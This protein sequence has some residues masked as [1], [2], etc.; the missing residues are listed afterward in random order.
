M[1]CNVHPFQDHIDGLEY[2]I[3]KIEDLPIDR[4]IS[5][6]YDLYELYFENRSDKTFSL[7]GYS[8]DLGVNYTTLQEINSMFKDK[9]SKKLTVLSLAASTASIALGGIAKSAATTA[10][11]SVGS[12]RNRN[13]KIED[14]ANFLST[15]KTYVL[16]PGLTLSLLL[17]V[18]KYS[19]K[20]PYTIKFICRDEDL[21][22]NH[23]VINNKIRLRVINAD[24]EG[25]KAAPKEND[26]LQTSGENVIAAPALEQYK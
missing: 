13:N 10:A 23:I 3:R 18:D 26:N 6:R 2:D 15:N 22:I 8:L 14:N 25:D 24:Y 4:S 17:F 16:Y 5:K 20:P 7:P 12:L 11:R 19:E 1:P 21:N 9:S